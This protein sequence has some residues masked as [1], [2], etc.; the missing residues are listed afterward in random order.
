MPGLLYPFPSHCH[1][2]NQATKL[3]LPTRSQAY[4][5]VTPYLRACQAKSSDKQVHCVLS[6]MQIPM[7]S[8]YHLFIISKQDL[9][10]KNI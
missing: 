3:Y 5:S 4:L 6:F 10:R 2:S 9:K 8:V 1:S 7:A